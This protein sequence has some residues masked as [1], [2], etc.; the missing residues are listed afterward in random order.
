MT[1]L[2]NWHVVRCTPTENSVIFN[3]HWTMLCTCFEMTIGRIPDYNPN[4]RVF[5]CIIWREIFTEILRHNN[6]MYISVWV[7]Y[8][9]TKLHYISLKKFWGIWCDIAFIRETAHRYEHLCGMS[10]QSITFQG[11]KTYFVIIAGEDIICVRN[12]LT[13]KHFLWFLFCTLYSS[14]SCN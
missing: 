10:I 8:L 12:I 3:C 5:S 11:Y 2:W 1:E 9:Y 4:S 7:V 6:Y 13:K 14:V